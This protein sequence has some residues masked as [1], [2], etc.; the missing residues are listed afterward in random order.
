M[1]VSHNV[2][3]AN[4]GSDGVPLSEPFTLQSTSTMS[5]NLFF[6][7]FPFLFNF[8]VRGSL[9][10]S[11]VVLPATLKFWHR[12]SPI[13]K[14]VQPFS[15]VSSKRYATV[16]WPITLLIC[17]LWWAE[18]DFLSIPNCG[19]IFANVLATRPNHHFSSDIP[20]NIL[21]WG[22]RPHLLWT[23]CEKLTCFTL[24]ASVRPGFTFFEY[25]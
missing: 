6:T 15:G 4:F 5:P 13:R 7:G 18:N 21:V 25:D 23:L 11:R 3:R 9:V 24:F 20:H 22:G 8:P 17:D 2:R 19:H 14:P 1:T 16:A 12:W 10:V